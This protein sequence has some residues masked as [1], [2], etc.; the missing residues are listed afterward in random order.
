MIRFWLEEIDVRSCIASGAAP[1]PPDRDLSALDAVPSTRRVRFGD[2]YRSS[3]RGLAVRFQTGLGK[4]WVGDS[5]RFARERRR[6]V[7]GDLKGVGQP[8]VG[9]W[10]ARSAAEWMPPGTGQWRRVDIR[11][12]P[13][14]TGG[15][16]ARPWW[17]CEIQNVAIRESS[18]AE[19]WD[20]RRVRVPAAR[21]EERTGC[22]GNWAVHLGWSRLQHLT[23]SEG[24]R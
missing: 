1:T 4:H 13:S 7:Q 3:L 11:H 2:L 10:S 16:A 23:T 22:G 9:H 17:R 24:F 6:D 18:C 8:P 15:T 5:G 12:R 20:F 14:G 19:I 21:Q